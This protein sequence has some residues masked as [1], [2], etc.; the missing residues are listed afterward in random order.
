[1]F[2][3]ISRFFKRSKSVDVYDKNI[4]VVDDN[5]VDR[6]IVEE[7]LMKAGYQVVVY[8]GGEKLLEDLNNQKPDLFLLDCDMPNIHGVELCHKIK[9]MEEHKMIPVIFITSI[10]TPKNIVDCFEADA[11]NYLSKP[12][13]PKFLLSQV[14]LAL[15]DTER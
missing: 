14:E 15:E 8:S 7:I 9:D 4:I 12:I 5:D 2:E 10:D 6:R 11:E 3:F 13:S 1:M